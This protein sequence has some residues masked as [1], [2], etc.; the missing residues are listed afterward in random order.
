VS[1]QAAGLRES[2]LTDVARERLVA[3]MRAHV[4]LEVGRRDVR[5]LAGGA[6]VRPLLR[7]DPH[8]Q[9]EVA[10]LDELPLADA[11][12]E[13]LLAG[14]GPAVHL[15]VGRR[16]ERPSA[17]VAAVPT[18]PLVHDGRVPRQVGRL[19]EPTVADA[20]R[21]RSLAGVDS[22]VAL[23]VVRLETLLADRTR[24]PTLIGLNAI[25]EV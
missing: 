11:T 23:D 19:R 14:V 17:D 13:R 8:V 2:P 20:A 6:R 10:G 12:L 21:E 4:G 15:H 5:S 1:L 3:A 16:R 22:H 9:F 24:E 25:F 7:V 18:L